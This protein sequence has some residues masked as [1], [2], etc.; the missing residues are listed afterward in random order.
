MTRQHLLFG[1]CSIFLLVGIFLMFRSF[2]I[3]STNSIAKNSRDIVHETSKSSNTTNES[4]ALTP[5][6]NTSTNNIPGD[7]VEDGTGYP[8]SNVEAFE[9]QRNLS[10][11]RE[12]R[13]IALPDRNLGASASPE[14]QQ[15]YS[16]RA[17]RAK[18]LN[19][20]LRSKISELNSQLT[21]ASPSDQARIRSEIERLRDNQ[22]KREALENAAYPTQIKRPNIY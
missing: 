12:I 7:S 8:D 16:M 4:N 20:R 10:K 21:Y 18:Q 19:Q 3:D 9:K 13:P 5:R 14:Q 15:R 6:K 1:T 11:A 22:F 17:A 2:R